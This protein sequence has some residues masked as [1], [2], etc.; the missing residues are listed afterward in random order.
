MRKFTKRQYKNKRKPKSVK[1]CKR[2]GGTRGAMSPTRGQTPS[3]SEYDKAKQY[4]NNIITSTNPQ[5]FKGFM[6]FFSVDAWREWNRDTILTDNEYDRAIRMGTDR[7]N[8][9]KEDISNG[10]NPSMEQYEDDVRGYFIH[11]VH[12][13]Y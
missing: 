6:S 9:F 2:S 8:Q 11:T 3:R 5:N 1:N 12:D 13:A 4:L 10:M 7:L